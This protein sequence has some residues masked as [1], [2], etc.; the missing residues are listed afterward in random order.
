MNDINVNDFIIFNSVCKS[1]WEEITRIFKELVDYINKIMESIKNIKINKFK[2]VLKIYPNK[3][4]F[5]DK[6]MINY[7]C[8]DNC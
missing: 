6:R 3:T 5:R 7:Y 1:V 8:R 2:P 4:Y